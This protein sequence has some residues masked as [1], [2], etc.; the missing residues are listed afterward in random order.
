VIGAAAVL[1]AADWLSPAFAQ[2]GAGTTWLRTDDQGKG[3]TLALEACCNGG[4]RFIYQ[5]P[6]M[7]GQPATTMTVDSPLNGREAPA[8]V[9]G[10]PSGQTMSITKVDD[11]HYNAITK[12]NG[13]QMGT[14]TGVVSADGRAMTV[15]TV[16]Q[17][18]GQVFKITETWVRK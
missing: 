1:I 10:K 18:A 9:G 15:E 13:Q 12:T 5:I 17:A 14:H 11:R 4:L 6:P 7:G 3:I 16:S 8:L 2:L